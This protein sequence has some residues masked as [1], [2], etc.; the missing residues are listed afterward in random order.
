MFNLL[1]VFKIL[2][3]YLDTLPIQYCD[4]HVL[5]KSIILLNRVSVRFVKFLLTL[6]VLFTCLFALFVWS[7]VFSGQRQWAIISDL[8]V[9]SVLKN[10]KRNASA[11]KLKVSYRLRIGEINYQIMTH[12]QCIYFNIVVFVSVCV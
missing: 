7:W 2:F 1:F 3:N 12:L 11:S 4:W 9:F 8:N 5:C 10:D 6:L